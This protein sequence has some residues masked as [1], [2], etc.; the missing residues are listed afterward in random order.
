VSKHVAI[1]AN[2]HMKDYD[3][4]REVLS[5]VDLIIGVDGGLKHL[6]KMAIQPTI[7]MG[8]FDSIESLEFYKKIFPKAEVQTFEIR[9]DYTDSELAVRKLIEMK[10][11]RAVLLGVTGSRLDHTLAN[12]SLL[13]VLYDAGVKGSIVNE[14]N[15]IHYTED[16][17]DLEAEIGTNMSILPMSDKVTGIY[18]DGFEYPLENATLVYG[19]TTGISNVFAKEEASIRIESGRI[20]VM[21]SRD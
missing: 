19:S 4:F 6:E 2:G 20:V 3:R 11:E 13:K 17:L 12:I 8:D 18:L 7:M 5:K 15:V 21:Q 16:K 10:A 1:V 9:K 14:D